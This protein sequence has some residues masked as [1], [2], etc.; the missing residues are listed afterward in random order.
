MK[1]KLLCASVIML[2]L[3]YPYTKV[4]AKN[5]Y[6]NSRVK[7]AIQ[8]Y[9]SG[10]YT[11]CIQDCKNIVKTEP[12]NAFAYYYMGMAYTQAGKG[13]EAVICY[14][15]VLSLKT[16]PKLAEYAE[17]GRRCIETPVRC[18]PPKPVDNIAKEELSDIDKFVASPSDLSPTVRQDFQQKHLNAIKTEINGNKDLDNYNF[19]KLNDASQDSLKSEEQ[20]KIAQKPS[21]TEIKA[22]L[23]VLNDAEINPNDASYSSVLNQNSQNGLQQIINN[24]NPELLEINA[25]MGN[26]SQ[27]NQNNSMLNMV[28]YML[29]QNKSGNSSYSPQLMQAIMMNSM[30][31]NM[32]YNIDVDK[33]K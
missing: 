20:P 6:Y 24:Q 28:P 10:N 31:N 21:D 29:S 27:S 22:A 30:M 18:I 11:G 19:Q 17:T 3:V 13:D 25:L 15:K 32:D 9:K 4:S 16:E 1:K 7:V 12:E 5:S 23:K 26:N 8:K 14:K 2:F 33:D